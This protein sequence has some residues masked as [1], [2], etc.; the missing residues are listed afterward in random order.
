MKNN[1]R[2]LPLFFLCWAFLYTPLA[3]LG[4]FTVPGSE[5][6]VV[7][8]PK[9]CPGQVSRSSVEEKVE[10]NDLGCFLSV[11]DPVPG[12]WDCENDHIV[13]FCLTDNP[14]GYGTK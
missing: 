11:Y 6:E 3:L 10:S 7:V 1:N 9:P 14:P 8:E 2:Y 13:P 12:I 4:V 5:Q